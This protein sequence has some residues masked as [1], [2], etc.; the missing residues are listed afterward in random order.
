MFVRLAGAAF[1]PPLC[2]SCKQ[3]SLNVDFALQATQLHTLLT[4]PGGLAN[5]GQIPRVLQSQVHWPHVDNRES[6]YTGPPPP[7]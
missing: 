1:Q 7:P 4:Y 3:T 2:D 6:Q 5:A